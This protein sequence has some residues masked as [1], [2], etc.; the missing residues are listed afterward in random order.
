MLTNESIS[1][2]RHGAQAIPGP[3]RCLAHA[4]ISTP[5]RPFHH[6]QA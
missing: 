6:Y 5:C 1:N 2:A 3:V 4:A